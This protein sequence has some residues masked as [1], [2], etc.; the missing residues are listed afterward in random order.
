MAETYK[1][2][3]LVHVALDFTGDPIP[4][5]R[6]ASR[7][8]QI[9]F[10]YDPEFLEREMEISPLQMPLR[11]GSHF[12]EPSTF[13]GLPGVFQDS[14]PG[15]WSQ[16]LFD[17]SLR[18]KGIEPD[19]FHSL[20]RL[21]CI[22]NKGAGALIYEPS[23]AQTSAQFKIDLDTL[24]NQ[25]QRI[26][27]DYRKTE[28]ELF[29]TLGGFLNGSRPKI[30]VAANHQKSKLIAGTPGLNDGLEHWLVKFSQT[31]DGED[32]GAI[33]FVYSQMA[34]QAG[35]EMMET[36]LFSAKDCRG[37]FATKRFDREPGG[38]RMHLHSARGL[39]NFQTN[40]KRIDYKVL[41]ESALKLTGDCFQAQ[42]M[43]RLAVFNVLAHH[44]A[45]HPGNFSFLMN[46]DGKWKMAPAY[47]LT[48][49]SGPGGEHCTA[50]LGETRN[51]GENHLLKLAAH[52]QVSQSEAKNI[53]RQ[54]R[55]S[56][57]LWRSISKEVGIAKSKI[58]EIA[59]AINT[60]QI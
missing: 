10:E 31:A 48:Y 28:V 32:G 34:R 36:Y 49:S 27:E 33:E 11:E 54:T 51:P 3:T 57:S 53:I 23:K 5:G 12:I 22:G 6:L 14:L 35:V 24:A 19:Q 18:S 29:L 55:D 13:G 59:R 15:G 45:D 26:L 47:G 56:L 52:A 44:R 21:A 2:T 1:S 40:S 16:I 8:N 20:D 41:V 37:Y 30:V 4:V 7:R 9:F 17:R 60:A 43:Y 25:S 39:L 58:E 50:V 46:Q 38:E 42:K